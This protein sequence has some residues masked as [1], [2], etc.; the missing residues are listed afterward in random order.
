MDL[1]KEPLVIIGAGGLGLMALALLKLMDGNAAVLIEPDPVKRKV[2]LQM[3]AIGAF[4]P[5]A[6]ADGSATAGLGDGA[7]AVL[8]FVGSPAS[9]AQGVTMLR[10][11][12][13]LIM[14]GMYGGELSLPIPT[15]V[16][17]AIS[18]EGSYVGS[19]AQMRELMALVKRKGIPEIPIVPRPLSEINDAIAQMRE[20]GVVGRTVLQP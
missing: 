9:I 5:A 13:R 17:R 11:G 8:D 15:L 7:A 3:G 6:V 12:G 14:V 18:L 1:I 10:K 16:L 19:L 4:D 20:G 2:A